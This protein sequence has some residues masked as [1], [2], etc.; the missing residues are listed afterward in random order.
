VTEPLEA[1]VYTSREMRH[2]GWRMMLRALRPS[3][4]WIAVG[5]TAAL[6]WT[7]AK[8]S[9]PLLAQ[10]AID[11][12]IETYRP[13]VLVRWGLVIF[14]VT[15][16]VAVCTAGRRYAAFFISLRAEADLRRELFA[17]L[18][19]L[20]FG[21]HDR[22]Q[23]GQLMA[24]ANTD[25]R[26]IQ[27][28]L[29]FLPVAGANVVMVL[30]VAGVLFSID[31]KLAV[32]S[33]AA[34]P[35]LNLAATR[36]STRLHPLSADLQQSLADVSGVVEETLSGIRVVKGFG[37]ES[38][39][40]RH[41]HGAAVTVFDK[42]MGIARLRASFTPLIDLLPTVGLI[43]TLYVGG[44]EVLDHHLTIG[45]LIAF[46]FYILQLIF[47]LRLT[48]FLVA[49]ASRA[50]ASAAR[51]Y[52]VL[53]TA[54]AIVNIHDARR[55][56]DGAGEVRFEGVRFGYGGDRSVLDGLDLVVRGGEALALVG[57]TGCGK[58]TV[59]RLIP[60]FYDVDA[61]S[62]LL[63]GVDVRILELSELRRS[64]G[65]VFED[66]FLFGDS[67]RTNIAFADPEAP[68]ALVERAARLA[69]ADEFIRE[70]PDG[71]DTVLGERGFSLSGGQR[72]RIAI[73]RAIFADPRVLVL[74]DATSSVDPT[75]EH[76]IRAAMRE[77]MQGRTTLIIA[78]RPA[79]VA[80]ADRVV[81]LGDNGRVVATGT[82]EDLLATS[83]RYRQVLAEG[84]RRSAGQDA[85]AESE[86][87]A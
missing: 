72:Q 11:H 67:V 66:T 47:P 24:R 22:A 9:I 50:S 23:T 78:H 33:L 51:V 49:A 8:V 45:Q 64:V 3:R 13:A 20:H 82:H 7:V 55:P 40:N 75:K 15:L 87:T 36:F 29:V 39:Q 32:V 56:V 27:L 61:G 41:M 69:G 44:H 12:G 38:I 10:R 19:R 48:A 68:F 59:A 83:E 46:N 71:Y 74:D 70:L 53:S 2:G 26:Q 76:E 18:Q 6:L 31:P 14:A 54:P 4:G 63:D 65:I 30:G 42:A 37:S 84:E 35:F 52:A 28:F 79:T 77:V 57:P 34:L 73:A 81:L 17:H 1:D 85:A 58:S 21:Y 25:L 80:L 16:V 86:A 60:R 43:A 62:V 5:V